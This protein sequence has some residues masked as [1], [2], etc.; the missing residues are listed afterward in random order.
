VRPNGVVQRQVLGGYR[1]KSGM[2]KKQQRGKT[3]TNAYWDIPRETGGSL[4]GAGK[5]VG[6]GPM[7]GEVGKLLGRKYKN[8]H[9]LRDGGTEKRSVS[10]KEENLNS[11]LR[12]LMQ[13]KMG[14]LARG[15]KKPLK[16]YKVKTGGLKV[17]NREKKLGLS[18]WPSDNEWWGRRN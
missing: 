7:G 10:G 8:T 13:G 12:V 9:R 16:G 15:E 6:K 3:S 11:Q 4:V 1:D 14:G 5:E 17:I 2:Y 18:K